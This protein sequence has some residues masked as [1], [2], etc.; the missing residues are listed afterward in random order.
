MEEQYSMLEEVTD[1]FPLEYDVAQRRFQVVP[2][3]YRG[4]GQPDGRAQ[5]YG[6]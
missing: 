1:E 2:R 4:N 5:I 6:L 3:K